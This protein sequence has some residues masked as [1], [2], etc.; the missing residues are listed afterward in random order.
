M[1]GRHSSRIHR[2]FSFLGILACLALSLAACGTTGSGG[3]GN[4]NKA[5]IKIG[6]SLSLSGDFSSDGEG[7]QQGYQLWADYINQHGGLLGRQ[8]QLDIV[9]DASSPQQVATNYQKLI[10]VDKVDLIFGPFSSLLTKPAS[11]VANRYGFAMVEGAGG[12]P[13]VFDRGLDNI[14]D[15]SLPVVKNLDTVAGLISSMPASQRPLTVA[16]ATEDD[17]FTQPQVDR[18]KGLLEAAGLKTVYYK[19][20]PAETTDYAPIA[21]GIINSKADVVIAGTH[22]QDITA[23]IRQFR[24]QNYVPKMLI[25]TAGPDQGS[26][27]SNEIGAANTQAIM[28]PNGWYPKLNAFQN[29]TF[30]NAYVAKYGGSP[31][32]ISI[33]AAEGFAVGQVVAQAVTQNQS[34]DQHKLIATLHSGTFQSCQG[35]VKFDSTGQNT[36]AVAYLFQWQNNALQVV[37]PASA[38]TSQLVYPKPAWV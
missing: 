36:A 28:V 12:A 25:A 17:P 6:I 30:V 18:V 8:V 11:V 37:Y 21:L 14:F 5:P 27:F 3:S 23:F 33:D 38:A 29:D 20:Y 4:G 26:Q 24:Q 9:S 15:V 19:V 16:Y 10:T 35:P 22:F 34:L 31:D 1:T 2:V 7:F 13:S 32:L